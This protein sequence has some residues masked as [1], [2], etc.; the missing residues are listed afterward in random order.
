[1][2]RS[3]LVILF[4]ASLASFVVAWTRL[5]DNFDIPSLPRSVEPILINKNL[6]HTLPPPGN[7]VD[8]VPTKATGCP[9]TQLLETVSLGIQSNLTSSLTCAACTAL[10]TVIE[11]YIKVDESEQN[12]IET[13][14][15][16][17]VTLKLST[18]EVCA[19]ITKIFSPEV[20]YVM[21]HTDRGADAFCS[22]IL[23]DSCNIITTPYDDWEVALPAGKPTR[24][25]LPIPKEGAPSFKVLQIADPHFDPYYLEGANANCDNGILCCRQS[26]GALNS[27]SDAAGKWGDFRNCDTP[28][29]TIKHMYQHIAE[30]HP[31]CDY[32]MFTGDSVAHDVWNQTRDGNLEILLE[33]YVQLSAAFPGVPVFP[34]VG[35]HESNPTES[36]PQAF[37]KNPKYS[38]AWLYNTLDAQWKN[39]LPASASP[40]V[41]RGAFY[42]VLAR[43]GFRIISINT[44]FCSYLNFWQF[45]AP[46]DPSSQLKWLVYELQQAESNN[47][48]VH[49]IGHIPPGYS[50][51]SKVWSRNFNKIVQRFEYTITAQFFGHTHYDEFKVSYDLDD[52]THPVG[53]SYISPSV[54]PWSSLNPGYRIYY[55]DGDHDTTTRQVIDHETWVMDLQQANLLSLDNPTYYQLYSA[56]YAY[57]MKSLRPADWDKVIKDFSDDPN[58]FNQY[59]TYACLLPLNLILI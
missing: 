7:N 21:K 52:V 5:E 33:T 51:C 4:V 48:K 31:D 47:E 25:E 53:V 27:S 42:S 36:Y 35:N 59:Y 28:L 55:V 32:I 10:I 13:L 20:I 44:N 43:P 39:W 38:N 19:G 16:I 30:T 8:Q 41:L 37:I 24:H 12:I 11:T 9:L 40:T 18:P 17:C 50:D 54:T 23:S 57:N 15:T 56:R 46:D 26:N 29:R 14:N 49:I 6:T 3:L 34:N 58:L 22:Q 45:L 1:M 2:K